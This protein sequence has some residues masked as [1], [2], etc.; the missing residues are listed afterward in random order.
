LRS[1]W[2]LDKKS[3]EKFLIIAS[4]EVSIPFMALAITFMA[5]MTSSYSGAVPCAWQVSITF[6]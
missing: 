3:P 5:D 4:S 6:L 1:F 2:K